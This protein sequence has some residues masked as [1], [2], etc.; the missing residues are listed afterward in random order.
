MKKRLRIVLS[1]ERHDYARHIERVLAAAHHQV[2]AAVGP[3]DDLV[4]YAQQAQAEALIVERSEPTPALLQQLR[5]LHETQP[6]P[7]AVFVD[8]S[9]P[10]D[11][12]VAVKAGVTAYVV[13]G[14][15]PDR[16]VA[17][18]EAACARFLEFQALRDE[19]DQAQAKLAERKVVERAKGILM[20]RRRLPEGAAY[21]T[22]RK[23]AM[24]RGKRLAEVAE[25]IVTA[26]EMLAEN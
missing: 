6:L 26:E 23:M 4:V 5:R 25:S 1:T 20:I 3:E 14:F 11:I 22:L 2:V 19:R 7:V 13:D 16:V 8:R 12:Q 15:R 24:N 18:L 17:V 21:E 10:P 9:G